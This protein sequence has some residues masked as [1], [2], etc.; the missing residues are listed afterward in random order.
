MWVLFFFVFYNGLFSA[1]KNLN[2]YF[3]ILGMGIIIRFNLFMLLNGMTKFTYEYCYNEAKKYTTLKE[4]RVGYQWCYIVSVK[5][6]WLKTFTWLIRDD[7]K[8]WFK[9]TTFLEAKKY[10]SLREFRE[11][12]LGAYRA[13]KKNKWIDDYPWLKR[14]ETSF[15]KTFSLKD[16]IWTV[17]CYEIESKSNFSVY[18]GLTR[19]KL[20]ERDSEHRNNK[21][22]KDCLFK[23]CVENN[24]PIPTPKILLENLTAEEA[25]FNEN[26]Y[27]IIYFEE[28][29]NIINKGST[30]IG[31]G[32]LGLRPIYWTKENCY[33]AAKKCKTRIE[34]KTRYTRAYNVSNQN[35][36]SKD[37]Y[38]FKERTIK[39]IV[40][41]DPLT[42]DYKIIK[43]KED[44]LGYN[45]DSIRACCRRNKSTNGYP[46]FTIGNYIWVYEEDFNLKP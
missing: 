6:D 32:S 3:W 45:R 14:N 12:S 21:S 17:Y 42:K 24:I 33:Q 5:N 40:R 29:W 20:K 18:I 30:G 34:F 9:E 38:W 41:I 2:T 10:N 15:D 37:Y 16:K 13:A 23:Y 7:N 4:F 22:S 28:G 11:N 36:W 43:D 39:P 19:R 1:T 27:K 26:Y 35:G 25:Q 44:L 46:H 31:S 8:K